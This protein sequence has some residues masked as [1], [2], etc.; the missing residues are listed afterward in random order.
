MH[1]V[2]VLQDMISKNALLMNDVVILFADPSGN[3]VYL[4]NKIEMSK[5]E[6]GA[7]IFFFTRKREETVADAAEDSRSPWKGSLE[8]ETDA[9]TLF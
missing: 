6:S 2:V 8:E 5:E 7:H 1:V 3:K 9:E 4:N